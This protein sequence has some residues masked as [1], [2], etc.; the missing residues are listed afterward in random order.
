MAMHPTQYEMSQEHLGRLSSNV[1]R[2]EAALHAY[3][4]SDHHSQS[5]DSP[6]MLEMSEALIGLNVQVERLIQRIDPAYEGTYTG[7]E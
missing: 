1:T 4:N 7:N 6:F 3:I 2:L 5:P